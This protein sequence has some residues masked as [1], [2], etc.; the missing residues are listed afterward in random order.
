[1]FHII[2]KFYSGFV[3]NCTNV[4][5]ICLTVFFHLFIHDVDWAI[6]LLESTHCFKL[7]HPSISTT[8][9]LQVTHMKAIRLLTNIINLCS[10]EFLFWVRPLARREEPLEISLPLHRSKSPD[11]LLLGAH[12][13]IVVSFDGCQWVF[14]SGLEGAVEFVVCSRG[15]VH[16]VDARIDIFVFEILAKHIVLKSKNNISNKYLYICYTNPNF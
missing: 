14:R 1:M 13:G 2:E 4:V 12:L 15:G 11:W 3:L 9:M 7:K 8:W 10:W 6:C 5:L 16:E